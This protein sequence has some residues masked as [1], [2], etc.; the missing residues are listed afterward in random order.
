MDLEDDPSRRTIA[1][2]SA[3]VPPRNRSRV[4]SALVF[5]QNC[6]HGYRAAPYPKPFGALRLALRLAK[7]AGATCEEIDLVLR[8]ERGDALPDPDRR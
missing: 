4:H 1:S 6:G 5:L 7:E 2:V 8:E 3:L